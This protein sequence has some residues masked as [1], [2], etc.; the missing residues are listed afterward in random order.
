V[1]RAYRELAKNEPNRVILIDGRIS[2]D[3]IEN[4][5]WRTISTRFPDLA[6]NQQLTIRNPQS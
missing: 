1:I 6:A 3:A 5:I 2:I 4:E